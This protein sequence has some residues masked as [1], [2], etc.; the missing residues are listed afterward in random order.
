MLMSSFLILTSCK[1][2]EYEPVE[3]TEE[4]KRVILTLSYENKSYDVKYELYRALFL[5]YKNEVDGGDKSVWSGEGKDEYIEKINEI[6]ISEAARIY[7]AFHICE[8]IGYDLYSSD[9]E[10]K[11]ASYVKASVEG[12]EIDGVTVEGYGSYEAYLA[13]LK[14]SNLNYSVQ[15]LLFRY[16][17][18]KEVIDEYYMGTPSDEIDGEYENGKIEYTR[19][20]VKEYYFSLDCVRVLR[21]FLRSDISYDTPSRAENLRQEMISSAGNGESSVI[22]TIINQ[23]TSSIDEVTNGFVIGR[24]NLDNAYYKELTEAAFKLENGDVSPV[25]R[26]TTDK[27]DGY[28]VMYRAEKTEENFARN[29]YNILFAYLSDK[30]GEKY[31]TTE[32]ALISSASFDSGATLDYAGI[33]MQ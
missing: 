11:I 20:S 21:A 27:S 13:A 28:Y 5:N 15:A 3:S 18:A 31:D 24:H 23:S 12:G 30:V 4:E 7:S 29:Y 1:D 22:V 26:V 25:I 16:S 6:I 19:E 2:E 33:S 32:E 14:A 10:E 9:V 17:I 8:K